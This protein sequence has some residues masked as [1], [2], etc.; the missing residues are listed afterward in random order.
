MGCGGSK[1]EEDTDGNNARVSGILCARVCVHVVCNRETY[2]RETRSPR[3]F[4]V[5]GA[6]RCISTHFFCLWN[7]QAAVVS[8][9]V[10]AAAAPAPAPSKSSKA[11]SS[12]PTKGKAKFNDVYKLGKEVSVV[13]KGTTFFEINNPQVLPVDL[14][15]HLDLTV[16]LWCIF[17]R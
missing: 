9:P 16:G 12:T 8:P 11:S 17:C 3:F 2:R 14:W 4:V 13:C 15:T 7:T 6:D 5:S 10:V 1:P